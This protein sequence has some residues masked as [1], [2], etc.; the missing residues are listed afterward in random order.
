MLEAFT[1]E[2]MLNHAFIEYSS[3]RNTRSR[4]VMGNEHSSVTNPFRQPI[5]FGYH[6]PCP[7]TAF[8]RFGRSKRCPADNGSLTRQWAGLLDPAPSTA[9][10][11]QACVDDGAGS[12]SSRHG[13][14]TDR[15]EIW[16]PLVKDEVNRTKKSELIHAEAYDHCNRQPT[17]A[18]TRRK[19]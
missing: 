6:P 13:K 10:V 15:G 1:S 16:C 4:C 9:R 17:L 18:R 8:P 14:G 7:R 5:N 11:L 3:N 19:S 12:G 2:P